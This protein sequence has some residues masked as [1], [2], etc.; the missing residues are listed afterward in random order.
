V[1]VAIPNQTYYEWYNRTERLRLR[2]PSELVVGFLVHNVASRSRVLDLGCGSGRHA[3]LAAELGHEA[4]G[5]DLA[6]EGLACCRDEASARGL[7]VSVRRAGMADT[8][9]A[10][11]AFDAVVC[12]SALGGNTLDEQRRVIDEVDRLLRPGGV[13]M[14]NFY[15][16]DDA[17]AVR[18]RTEG[19]SVGGGSWVLPH[20]G[21]DPGRDAE[22][23][24]FLMH[25]SDR[26]EI[27]GLLAGFETVRQFEVNLPYGNGSLCDG[28]EPSHLLYA[29]ARKPAAAD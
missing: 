25:V 13:L 7:T 14:A 21:A 15:G 10:T 18:A 20:Y 12:Y 29:L 5:V 1:S 24:E 27:A 23:H 22:V 26:D 2:Y 6:E 11:A 3:L 9:L 16:P 8:G 19:R 4:W 28:A 17:V